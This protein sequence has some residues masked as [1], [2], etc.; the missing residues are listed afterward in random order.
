MN[1]YL[2]FSCFVFVVAFI[3]QCN[4]FASSNGFYIDPNRYRELLRKDQQCRDLSNCQG[5]ACKCTNVQDYVDEQKALYYI[6][7][8]NNA[9]MPYEDYVCQ[10]DNACKERFLMQ[11]KNA[12]A[13]QNQ[14]IKVDTNV[15]YSGD[16]NVNHSGGVNYNHNFKY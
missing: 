12:Q 13:L 15:N 11:Q 16:I 9:G 1:K 4:V 3:F 7:Q 10:Q 6:Q 2:I 5:W 8:S 14:K